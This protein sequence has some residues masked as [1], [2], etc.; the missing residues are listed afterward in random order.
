MDRAISIAEIHKL[1]EFPTNERVKPIV[2][3]MVSPGICLGAWRCLKWKHVTPIINDK[4][5]K[6]SS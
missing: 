5:G 3:V 4:I 6:M 1:L 2:L